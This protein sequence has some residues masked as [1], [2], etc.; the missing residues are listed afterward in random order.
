MADFLVALAGFDRR[1]LWVELGHASLF[2]F[3]RHELGLSAG[4]AQYRKT[5]AE[6]VQRFS[7]VEAALREGRLCLS[8][9]IELA[10]V[11]TPENAAEV[12]P[13]F[14]GLSSREAAFVAASIRP[15]AYPPRREVVVPLRPAAAAAPAEPVTPMPSA[16]PPLHGERPLPPPARDEA[17]SFRAPETQ[18]APDGSAPDAAGPA[19]RPA[20]L[21][22]LIVEPLAADLARFHMTVSRRFLAKL[23]AT[24]E[25]LSHSKPG[26]SAEEALEACMDLLLARHAKRRG[27]VEKPRQTA[28]APAWR[29]TIPAAVRREVWRRAGGHCEW[30]LH[31]GGTCGSTLRLEFAHVTAKA[32]GGP[33][34]TANLRLHCRFHNL[35][36]ARRDFGD[37]LV[38]RYTRS[39][40]RVAAFRAPETVGTD[41]HGT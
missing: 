25:A 34:T 17:I 21:A 27:L 2:S 28:R 22:K 41:A 1:R 35:L 8:S 20:A 7:E 10:K 30:P 24:K 19:T 29:T 31:E 32:R 23:K 40:A 16:A 37:A 39:S 13:R 6:L 14:Y 3:L 38:D 5:A 9:V 36:T 11:I 12:L 15:A 26:A 18:V 4:A 33:A